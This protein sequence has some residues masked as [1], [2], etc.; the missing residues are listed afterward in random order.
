MNKL[1]VLYK[2]TSTGKIQRWEI[3]VKEID[4]GFSIVTKHGYVD[5]KIVEDAGIIVSEGK[6]LGRSN[7]TS[8]LEQAETEAQSKWTK[9]K[10]E[11]YVESINDAEK[12]VVV[13]P[14]LANKY[15][16]V[17]HHITFP[18]FVQRKY[19]GTRCLS[20]MRGGSVEL[21]SRKGKPFCFMDHIRAELAELFK[22][23]NDDFYLDGELYS[24]ELTFQQIVGTVKK[25]KTKADEETML[26]IQ[27]HVYDCFSLVNLNLPYEYKAT[28]LEK[29]IGNKYNYIKMVESVEAHS[30]E[31]IYHLHDQFVSE[32]WEGAIVRNKKLK[33]ELDKRSNELLKVKAFMD[34]EFKIIGVQEACGNDVG[35]AIFVCK[36][37]GDD[38]TFSC[39]PKGTREQRR[40]WFV[41]F[42]KYKGKML[43][44]EFFEKTDEGLPRFPVG[45]AIRAYE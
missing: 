43:T 32:G 42:E 45:K 26:K 23:T 24:D 6:N 20:I 12:D 22:E 16:K 8:P 19:D 1:P 5:G 18:C 25:S 44:V 34:E 31:D 2:R 39:R 29:L 15:E 3:F 35:T 7:Q 11:G 36:N 40:E 13:L 14:M 27:Y 38:R 28:L 21:I 10:D 9:K 41:N 33:Y 37:N 17:K 4:D 30:E